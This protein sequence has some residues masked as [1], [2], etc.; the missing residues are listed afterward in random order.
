MIFLRS[1]LSASTPP[2]MVATICAIMVAAATMPIS[3]GEPEVAR[4]SSG[5]AMNE[6]SWPS[7]EMT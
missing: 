3:I 2:G 6:I 7:S 4:I 5:K 1:Q